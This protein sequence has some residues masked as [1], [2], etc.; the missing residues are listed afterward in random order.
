MIS[1]FSSFTGYDDNRLISDPRWTNKQQKFYCKPTKWCIFVHAVFLTVVGVSSDKMRLTQKM[2]RE[3]CQYVILVSATFRTSE[4]D[5]TAWSESSTRHA[6]LLTSR[7]KTL[8]VEDASLQIVWSLS[9]PK[10]D[11][12]SSTCRFQAVVKVT[13]FAFSAAKF[14]VNL[15]E[16]QINDDKT[17]PYDKISYFTKA[18]GHSYIYIYIYRLE[19]VWEFAC[20]SRFWFNKW[21]IPKELWAI[22]KQG[23]SS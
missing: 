4:Y 18:L 16:L 8:Y 1:H 17:E 19:A 13:H 22:I 11:V 6:V 10:A 21:G 14:G 5:V 2:A 12:V 20:M 7:D 3:L 15:A 23:Y 9:T